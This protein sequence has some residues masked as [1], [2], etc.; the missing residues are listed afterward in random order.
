M[1]N[2]RLIIII[3]CV[4]LCICTAII[5]ITVHIYKNDVF[6]NL[7]VEEKQQFRE[8]ERTVHK[9]AD[10]NNID[11]SEWPDELILLLSRNEETKDFV[12]SYP[13]RKTYTSEPDM[14][15]YLNSGSVPLFMQWD[16]RWGYKKYGSSVAGITGCGPVCLSMAATYLL[17]NCDYSPNKMIDFA[18]NEGYCSNGNGSEWALISEGGKKLGL[19]VA[20]LPL[21]ESRIRNAL[22]ADHPVICVMGPGDFTTSGHFII[23]TAVDNGM[24]RVNDPNSLANSQKLWNYKTLEPQIKNLWELSIG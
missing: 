13:D 3:I 9:Y 14:S 20:E 11:R 2:K 22:K 8:A 12:L 1:K 10:W 24:Y 4:M 7:S 23:I 19:D 5:G 16:K 21:V 6:F 18:I 15:L 17:N